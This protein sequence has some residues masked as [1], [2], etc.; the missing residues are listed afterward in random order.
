[1]KQLLVATRS[2]GKQREFRALLT[3]L[4]VTILFPDDIGLLHSA[5]EDSLEVFETFE[6]N[7]RAKARWFAARSGLS[8]LADDSGL[9]VDVLGGAPGVHS[10]RFAGLDGGDHLVRAANNAA[11]LSQLAAV[12]MSQRAARYRCVLVWHDPGTG[13]E[14]VRAGTTEGRIGSAPIGSSGFGYDPLFHSTELGMTFGEATA[15]AKHSVSH[16]GRAAAAM[17]AAMEP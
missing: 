5:A 14:L 11:L 12:P 17:M 3:P 4:G 16:R 2:R 8:T 13:R 6:E 15:E 10:K 1:M 9:E 7:A